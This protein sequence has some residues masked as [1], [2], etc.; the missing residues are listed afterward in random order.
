M[1]AHPL[2]FLESC[3]L[4]SAA[5]RR[6]SR[7]GQL[8]IISRTSF[9]RVVLL[10]K[11]ARKTFG[12]RYTSKRPNT[13]AMPN[14]LEARPTQKLF[15]LFFVAT[16]LFSVA[17][18]QNGALAAGTPSTTGGTYYGATDVLVNS[19]QYLSCPTT[20]Q[21]DPKTNSATVTVNYRGTDMTTKI[22]GTLRDGV[23]HGRSEGRFYG[24]VYVQAMNYVLK[25][26]RQS[27]T[28]KTTSWKVNPIPGSDNKPETDVYRRTAPRFEASEERGEENPSGSDDDSSGNSDR[29]SKHKDGTKTRDSDTKTSHLKYAT[30]AGANDAAERTKLVKSDSGISKFKV[31]PTTS[32][33]K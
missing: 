24:L 8:R 21:F 7:I 6:V 13:P 4:G 20:L 10:G 31:T 12:C 15:S 5:S 9:R 28:V 26:D 25:F 17:V 2:A 33:K 11:S 30:G 29:S 19:N 32:H 18:V 3:I 1:E 27:G 16:L 22:S 14:S 23:F